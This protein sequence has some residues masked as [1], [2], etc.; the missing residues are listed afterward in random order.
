MS[1]FKK[2]FVFG[3]L[4]SKPTLMQ[5]VKGRPYCRLSVATQAGYF[6]KD[7]QESNTVW[8]SIQV[9][10]RQAEMAAERLDK[11]RRVFV[12]GHF[13]C[14]KKESESGGGLEYKNWLTA[15]RITFLD[16]PKAQEEMG[17]FNN[18]NEENSSEDFPLS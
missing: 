6:G 18:L 10:G 12:E 2:I 5:T 3:R 14:S 17:I 7:K 11:G 15:D 16:S 8:H 9:F 1:T 4:G 13:E